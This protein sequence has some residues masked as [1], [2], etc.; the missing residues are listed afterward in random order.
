MIEILKVM[1]IDQNLGR[2]IQTMKIL[3]ERLQV[4]KA[5]TL[6]ADKIENIGATKRNK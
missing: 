2:I 4:E 1:L 3:R 6:K 5:I